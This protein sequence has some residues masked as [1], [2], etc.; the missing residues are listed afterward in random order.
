MNYDAQCWWRFPQK[1]IWK[2]IV[3]VL[4]VSIS[5]CA[6]EYFQQNHTNVKQWNCFTVDFV[7]NYLLI[8]NVMLIR[9]L[10]DFINKINVV[11]IL[12]LHTD[13]DDLLFNA[14]ICL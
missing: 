14:E 1:G 11:N 2:N 5:K 8:L 9:E 7:E 13:D 12:R 10:Y 6:T 3:Y 4:W